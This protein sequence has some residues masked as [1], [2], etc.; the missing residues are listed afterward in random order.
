LGQIAALNTTTG[1]MIESTSQ[2]L[3]EQS[4]DVH[5]QAAEA[6]VGIE[7]LQAAFRNLYATLDMIDAYKLE[8]LKTMQG[9][10]DALTAQVGEAQAYLERSRSAP[11][12]RTLASG[13]ELS[14]KG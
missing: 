10:I 11:E 4:G 14:L 3:K 12:T 9:S 5:K 2:M 7:K 1:E 13:G 8:A 6:A